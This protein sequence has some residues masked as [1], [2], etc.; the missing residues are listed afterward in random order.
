M[1]RAFTLI[2]LMIV[3]V[4]VSVLAGLGAPRILKFNR[5][6]EFNDTVQRLAGLIQQGREASLSS[7]EKR[8]DGVPVQ[9]RHGFR[10]VPVD[11]WDDLSSLVSSRVS[12]QERGEARYILE[13]AAYGISGEVW[14]TVGG[15]AGYFVFSDTN[16]MAVS[17]GSP[18]KEGDLILFDV[19]GI[20]RLPDGSPC[21]ND[22]R[23]V[24][25]H[26]EFNE[27]HAKMVTV[28]CRTGRITVDVPGGDETGQ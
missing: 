17:P 16:R 19:Q 3:V 13:V 5:K 27:S 21:T 1:R 20:P 8:I 2:E 15:D 11:E 4:I 28:D 10:L 14:E 18:L 9:V 6:L 24:L 12:E 23:L 22:P 25:M 26:D 7:C